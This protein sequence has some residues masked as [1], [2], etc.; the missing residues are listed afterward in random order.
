MAC[1]GDF[2]KS[3]VEFLQKA[4]FKGIYGDCFCN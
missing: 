3:F 1:L 4:I 2:L